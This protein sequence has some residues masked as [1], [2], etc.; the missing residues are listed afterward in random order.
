MKEGYHYRKVDSGCW[1]WLRAV[2]TDGYGT[3][4]DRRDITVGAHRVSWQ[5]HKGEIPEGL[6]VLHKC[7]N[8]LCVNPDHLFLGTHKDN[9]KDMIGKGRSN[10][11]HLEPMY[12]AMR[13]GTFTPYIKGSKFK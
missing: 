3:V 7:D 11:K 5:E 2:R 6:H 10:T 8:K 1:E 9:M 12:E 13:A 4:K